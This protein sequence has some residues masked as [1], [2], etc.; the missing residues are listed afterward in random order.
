MLYRFAMEIIFLHDHPETAL[1]W[2][3]PCMKTILDMKGVSATVSDQ[4]EYGLLVPGPDGQLLPAKTPT[5][6]ASNSPWMLARLSRRCQRDHPHQPLLGGKSKSAENYSI[7]LIVEILRG[8]RDTQ[9]QRDLGHDATDKHLHHLMSM[10]SG[11][12]NAG[13]PSYDNKFKSDDAERKF[14]DMN[15]NVK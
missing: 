11:F 5:K 3:E 13:T 15:I 9:D 7:E 12:A 2:S 4:C 10:N 14:E 1:S 6:W 8:I